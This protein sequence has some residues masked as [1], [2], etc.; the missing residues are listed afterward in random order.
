MFGGGLRLYLVV[1]PGVAH[2]LLGTLGTSSVLCDRAHY[3][4]FHFLKPLDVPNITLNAFCKMD[5]V[6][7]KPFVHPLQKCCSDCSRYCLDECEC[8]Y[9]CGCCSLSIKTH[10]TPAAEEPAESGDDEGQPHK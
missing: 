4:R 9:G 3:P 7:A 5:T 2:G 6:D 8:E 1:L 10:H